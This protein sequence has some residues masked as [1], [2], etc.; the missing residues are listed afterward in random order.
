MTHRCPKPNPK[1]RKVQRRYNGIVWV[2]PDCPNVYR[3]V[4]YV[5]LGEA[6]VFWILTSDPVAWIQRP[7]KE[8]ARGT[9]T[10]G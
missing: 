5:R 4:R 10:A 6:I 7:M 9:R 3:L 1:S 8:A 2:C